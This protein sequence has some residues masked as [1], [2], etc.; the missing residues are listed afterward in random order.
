VVLPGVWGQL[1]HLSIDKEGFDAVYME[2]EATLFYLGA[3][4]QEINEFMNI[5]ESF[6]SDVVA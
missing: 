5:I 6:R 3:P 4:A 1:P 2:I